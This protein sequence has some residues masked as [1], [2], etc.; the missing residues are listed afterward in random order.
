MILVSKGI[1]RAA[2]ATSDIQISGEK[3]SFEKER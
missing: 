3:E 2:R 1:S